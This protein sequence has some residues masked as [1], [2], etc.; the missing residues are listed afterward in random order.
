MTTD[1]VQ[2]ACDALTV[3]DY[4]RV[5][6]AALSCD[7]GGLVAHDLWIASLDASRDGLRRHVQ[8]LVLAFLATRTRRGTDR[9]HHR[10][11]E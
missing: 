1:D 9:I 6:C 5:A 11:P 10:A 4:A 8:M 3:G 2:R 7:A